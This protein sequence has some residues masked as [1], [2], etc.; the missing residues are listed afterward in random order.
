M[1]AAFLDMVVVGFITGMAHGPLGFLLAFLSGPPIFFIVAL[2]YF[3][4]LWAWKGTTIGGIVLRLQ[5]VR[6]DGGP[7]TFLV[8]L[9]RGLAAAL[10][11]VVLFLG[12][13]WIGWDRDKQGWHDKIAG[14]IVVRLSR[15]APLV[16]L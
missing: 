4:G 7:L 3:A 8:A 6:H 16:C 15:S 11:A 10:S 5:V 1:G 14:T 2:A 12:F 9:V 13:F